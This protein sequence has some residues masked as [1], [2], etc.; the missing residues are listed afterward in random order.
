[1][2]DIDL[3]LVAVLWKVSDHVPATPDKAERIADWY[4]GFALFHWN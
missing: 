3:I 1:M 2:A 4:R